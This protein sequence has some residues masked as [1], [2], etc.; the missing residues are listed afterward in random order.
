MDSSATS[1]ICLSTHYLSQ[2]RALGKY[3]VVLKVGNKASVATLAIGT[4]SVSW[5]S[6]YV[7]ILYD[8]LHI[9]NAIQNVILTPKLVE[10]NYE[11]SFANN[12]CYIHYGNMCMGKA[13]LVNG[14]YFLKTHVCK[15]GQQIVARPIPK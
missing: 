8:Y 14:L 13:V 9:F 5:L 4:T 15:Y 3:K 12:C 1:Y 2:S 6:R 10:Q 7:L 11:F